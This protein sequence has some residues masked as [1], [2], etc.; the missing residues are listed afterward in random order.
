M[1]AVVGY[2]AAN[3][4]CDQLDGIIGHSK[5]QYHSDMPPQDLVLSQ[6]KP[7]VCCDPTDASIFVH[8]GWRREPYS[9]G[10]QKICLLFHHKSLKQSQWSLIPEYEGVEVLQG[11][12]NEDVADK[13]GENP[14]ILYQYD[15][16]VSS[17]VINFFVQQ[18]M[19]M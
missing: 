15:S 1:N 17:S 2:D 19:N 7:T 9:L 5:C 13:L 12:S 10:H 8:Q 11:C 3:I 4:S 16:G 18:Y 14:L 6:E